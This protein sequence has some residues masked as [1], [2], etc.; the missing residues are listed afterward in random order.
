MSD[1][2]RPLYPLVFIGPMGAGKTRIGRRV[3]KALDVPFLDTDKIIVAEHGPIAGIFE[4]RGEVAFRALEKDAVADA[5][6]ERAV[7]SLGGGAVLN[8]ETR[9]AL[10]DKTVVLLTVSADAVA[11][12]IKTDKRPLLANG[13]ADWQRIYDER[14]AIYDEL[15]TITFDTSTQP[16]E[17]IAADIATW[18]KGRA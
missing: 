12:R 9:A 8:P 4:S 5:L 2:R 17:R 11:A 14:R 3:A 13:T 15:A 16:I 10:A 6:A 7:V 18:A 1:D